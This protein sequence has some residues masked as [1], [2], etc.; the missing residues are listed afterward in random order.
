MYKK[1]P[2]LDAKQRKKRGN[3]VASVSRISFCAV[4]AEA[5]AIAAAS[6][7]SETGL[8][9]RCLGAKKLQKRAC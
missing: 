3:D 8:A 5:V 1:W 6:A 7:G 4:S 2:N 9:K